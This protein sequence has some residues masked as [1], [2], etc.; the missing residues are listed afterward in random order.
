MVMFT[1]RERV[2]AIV[3]GLIAFA[4][5]VALVI[6]GGVRINAATVGPNS[7][8]L[9][10]GWT[11][12]G[13][14]SYAERLDATGD[15]QTGVQVTDTGGASTAF[16]PAA[17]V[18]PLVIKATPGHIGS[19]LITAAGTTSV[20]FYDNATACSGNI[21]GVTPATT[22]VGQSYAFNYNAVNGI[23]ACGAAGSAAVTLSYT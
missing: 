3:A 10:Y 23:T 19:A 1:W 8:V 14:A 6:A 11:A 7:T 15:S 20:T 18:A 22:S 21:I 12:A 13:A 9:A 2:P 5:C 4:F 17:Q 16:V